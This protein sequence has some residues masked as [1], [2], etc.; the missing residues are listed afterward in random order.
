MKNNAVT[1]MKIAIRMKNTA[2]SEWS[3]GVI[4][5]GV[6]LLLL[7]EFAAYHV[8]LTLYCFVVIKHESNAMPYTEAVD[9]A[10]DEEDSKTKENAFD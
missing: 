1:E 10:S 5:A 3:G 2:A 7:S 8:E 4:V 6:V 9:K